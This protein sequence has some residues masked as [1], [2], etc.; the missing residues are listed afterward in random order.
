MVD[1]GEKAR[2]GGAWYRG[3]LVDIG[4]PITGEAGIVSD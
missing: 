1:Q 4:A 2:S 3:L